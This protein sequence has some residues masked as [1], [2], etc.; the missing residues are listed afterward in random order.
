MSQY[1]LALISSVLLSTP[2]LL[3]TTT[4]TTKYYTNKLLRIIAIM[5]FTCGWLLRY[6]AKMTLGTL[7][8]Y[9]IAPPPLLITTGPYTLVV[10]PGYTGVLLQI[11][12]ILLYLVGLQTMGI[13]VAV[14]IWS[15]A[16]CTLLIRIHD[17]ENML[18]TIFQQQWTNHVANRWHLIPFIW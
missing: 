13:P 6:W 5:T 18:Q 12:G 8:Q 2:I 4:T 7:F 10:H 14:A 3:Y 1:A 16:I 15:G 17:E 11:L 9:L